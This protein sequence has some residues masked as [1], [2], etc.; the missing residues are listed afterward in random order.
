MAVWPRP[1]MKILKLIVRNMRRNLFRSISAVLTIALATFIFTILVSVPAS[2]DQIVKDASTSLRVMIQN[3]TGPWYGL[4]ARYCD[5][6]EMMPG[7]ARCAALRGW[8]GK[9]QSDR[10]TIGAFAVS[11]TLHD[12]FPDYGM[13]GETVAGLSSTRRAAVVGS[14]LMRKYHWKTGQQI[15]LRSSDAGGFDLTFVLVGTIPSKKY[16]NSFIFRRD[17]L[18]EA[19]KAAGQEEGEDAWFLMARVENA[20]VIPMVIREVDETFKNSDYE[21]KTETEADAV[22][23]G[24]SEVGS[25]RGIVYSLSAVVLLTVL[26]IS[27]NAMAMMVR[28]R[29]SE[30]A[31][32]R[33]LGFGRGT[34][35]TVLLGECAIIGLAGG[36]IGASFA[37]WMFGAGVNL[38][39]V[40]GNVGALVVAP[41]EAANALVVAV[42]LSI[43]SGVLP[44]LNALRMTPALAFRQIV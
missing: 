18:T 12:V 42:A 33:A 32:M 20:D 2:M 17:Y 37:L 26:L 34:I 10:D 4:P 16:P 9:Y 38:G 30:V 5:Q 8:F 1:G 22:S 25:I 40:I 19:L 44:T 29:L 35:S 13:T 7:V 21:T 31:V 14:L 11:D 3:R 24:L 43:V 6:I 36:I 23:T 27:A 41:R 28:D 39:A 15:T